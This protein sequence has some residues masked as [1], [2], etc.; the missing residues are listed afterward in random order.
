M[1]RNS[2]YRRELLRHELLEVGIGRIHHGHPLLLSR[3]CRTIFSLHVTD[4]LPSSLPATITGLPH[5]CHD[6]LARHCIGCWRRAFV[7][8]DI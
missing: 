4:A 7:R 3:Q 5:A 1:A 8:P 6:L 2:D